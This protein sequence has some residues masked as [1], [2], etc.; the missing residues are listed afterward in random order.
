VEYRLVCAATGEL[1]VSRVN[2]ALA[3][4][5]T[6]QGGVSVGYDAATGDRYFQAVV[7]DALLGSLA[8]AEGE[9]VPAAVGPGPLDD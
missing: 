9:E 4:G 6:P 7:R 2:E 8:A 3:D 5:W 1:F